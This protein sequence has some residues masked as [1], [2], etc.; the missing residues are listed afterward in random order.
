MHF[1][2]KLKVIFCVG[3]KL[4]EYNNLKT[5]KDYSSQLSNII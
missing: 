4:E 1:L 3:E 5:K 2:N